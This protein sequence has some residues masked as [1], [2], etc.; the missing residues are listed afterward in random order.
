MRKNSEL[1]KARFSSPFFRS[2]SPRAFSPCLLKCRSWARR[3]IA[4]ARTDVSNVAFW[5]SLSSRGDH[6]HNPGGASIGKASLR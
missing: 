2:E 3:H 4:L 5:R 6:L 1:L